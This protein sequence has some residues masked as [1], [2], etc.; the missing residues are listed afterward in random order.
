VMAALVGYPIAA[1][2]AYLCA[3]LGMLA[4]FL[5]LSG[6]AALVVLAL[7]LRGGA[8]GAA[9]SVETPA[10]P[11]WSLA[12]LIPLAL[13]I[14]TRWNR[15]FVDVPGGLL[16]PHSVDHSLH[17]AFYWE[18][19]RGVPAEQLPTA[20]GIAFP[21]Y[22]FI[23]FLP[24][25][26]LERTADVPVSV[27]YHAI[28]PALRL[29]LLLG[30]VYL[31]VRLRTNDGRAATAA[32][33][34]YFVAAYAF[35]L[36]FD[37]RFVVGPSP[38]Y[39]FLRNEAGGGGLVVWAGVLCL[40]ALADRIRAA[41]GAAFRP[42]L[43]ACLLAALSF[44][45]KAQLFLLLAPALALSLLVAE[46][47][48]RTPLLLLG[49][50]LVCAAL[51]LL[52]RKPD[53]PPTTLEWRPGLFAELYVL[54]LL[55]RD[56]SRFVKSLAGALDTL[57]WG[58]GLIAAVPLALF[59]IAC[60]SPLVPASVWQALRRPRSVG[61]LDLFAAA[62][63]LVALPMCYGLSVVFLHRET[64][65]FEFRQAANGLS[66]LAV[67]MSVVA[68]YELLARRGRPAGALLL[69]GAALA[70]ALSAPTLLHETAYVPARA[71]IVL[72]PDEQCA[73][74]FLRTRTAPDAVVLA[75]RPGGARPNHHSVVAG[76]AGR[77]SVL[78]FYEGW[79]VDPVNARERDIRRFYD[80]ADDALAARILGRYK[81][82]YVLES[83]DHPLQFSRAGLEPAFANGRFQV[84]RV[85]G[86]PHA[87]PPAQLP[88]VFRL[89]DAL[90]CSVLP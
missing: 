44:G 11:H 21:S 70:C 3:R 48:R 46:R 84:W 16:Y 13:V 65:P 42:L 81:V 34:A 68:L 30:A 56:P 9:G 53:S 79:E 19:L 87:A 51:F 27:V 58:L 37:D 60:F 82:D 6:A 23:A 15:P 49:M 35:E 7:R 73:L 47:S 71:A 28:V 32:V 25:L 1:C 69:A 2:I 33:P 10:R 36:H 5:P 14:G 74:L 26:L 77:R 59:R 72:P 52:A 61:L 54:P 67:L 12:L 85:R 76:F 29:L 83:D 63:W 39:D 66:L 38:H 17:L 75:N 55:R 80:T 18:L 64:S 90:A 40:L 20:A 4:W 22:H 45:F 43:L 8:A 62:A 57:P 78:E 31:V 24:G 50:A 88:A 86:A 41:G 89:K